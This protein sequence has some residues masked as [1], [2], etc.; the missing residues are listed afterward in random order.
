VYVL[1]ARYTVR[2]GKEGEVEEALRAMTPLSLAEPGCIEYQVQRSLD[3]PSVYVLYEAYVDEDSYKAHTET[4]HFT[5]YVLE[6]A[7]P[8]LVSR[9]REFFETLA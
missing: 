1:I 2:P 4:A 6:T 5:Q 7:V 9:E 8:L 3:D